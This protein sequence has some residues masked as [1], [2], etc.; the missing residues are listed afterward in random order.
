MKIF[1]LIKIFNNFFYQKFKVLTENVLL[2]KTNRVRS[3]IEDLHRE[4]E[5]IRKQMEKERQNPTTDFVTEMVSK[6]EG[7]KSHTLIKPIIKPL[8][9]PLIQAKLIQDKPSQARVKQ[10]A[11]IFRNVHSKIFHI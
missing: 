4:G 6:M 7:R 3:E 9:A 5:E 1:E 2:E 11:I 10:R 8:K